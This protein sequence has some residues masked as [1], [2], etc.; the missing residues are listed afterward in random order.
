MNL[1]PFSSTDPENHPYFPVFLLEQSGP[2]FKTSY[3]F[4][5][6]NIIFRFCLKCVRVCVFIYSRECRC[7]KR[8][9]ESDPAGA[10]VKASREPPAWVLRPDLG[11]SG[12]AAG[13]LSFK[14]AFKK[15]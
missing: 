2:L 14:I 4:L 8:P 7:P 9:E 13:V 6:T 12:R 11:S 10:G 1:R 3:P 15:T 5:F